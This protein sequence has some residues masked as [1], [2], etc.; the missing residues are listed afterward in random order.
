MWCSWSYCYTLY[1]CPCCLQEI[2]IV[3]IPPFQ[4][5][6]PHESNQDLQLSYHM[7]SHY[8]FARA[9]DHLILVVNGYEVW[10]MWWTSLIHWYLTP[11]SW[12]ISCQEYSMKYIYSTSQMSKLSLTLRTFSVTGSVAGLFLT[13]RGCQ[14]GQNKRQVYST[15]PNQFK[16]NFN[17]FK[18]FIYP[19][20]QQNRGTK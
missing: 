19:I 20:Y 8:L 16:S 4:D 2:S 13:L 15:K 3:T 7:W 6:C 1:P 12:C 9:Y 17:T 14:Y 10:F 18:C 5:S 11:V